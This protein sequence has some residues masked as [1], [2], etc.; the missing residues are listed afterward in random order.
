[1]SDASISN[2]TADLPVR[3]SID[4]A[5]A[6]PG[7]LFR[8]ILGEQLGL[9]VSEAARRMDVSR[10]SLHAVLRGESAATADM[11][12]RFGRLVGGSPELYVQRQARRDLWEAERKLQ[13][14]LA[15]IVP[16]RR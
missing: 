5:P 14:A 6:H 11:A 4:R 1:M 13:T 12:L 7:E 2:N 3:R 15:A 9:S 8:E 10:Q 16:Y